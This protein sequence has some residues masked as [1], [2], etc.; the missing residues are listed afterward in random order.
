MN[1]NQRFK[2]R[3]LKV[4]I[5]WRRIWRYFYGEYIEMV[6]FRVVLYYRATL[7]NNTYLIMKNVIFNF[8]GFGEGSRF[9]LTRADY[10]LV[11]K[12]YLYTFMYIKSFKSSLNFTVA[13]LLKFLLLNSRLFILWQH[14]LVINICTFM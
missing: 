1:K 5:Y 6:N 2:V 7:F 13:L 9:N 12:F 3:S 11:S 4:C 8:L 10:L 14:A